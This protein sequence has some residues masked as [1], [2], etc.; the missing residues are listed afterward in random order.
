MGTS[1][2]TSR[3]TRIE[4]GSTYPL[5]FSQAFIWH[6]R[7]WAPAAPAQFWHLPLQIRIR[8][9]LDLDVFLRALGRLVARHESLRT[10]F[11]VL[12]SGEPVQRIAAPGP[13]VAAVVDLRDQTAELQAREVARL[14]QEAFRAPFDLDAAAPF[15]PMVIQLADGEHLFFAVAH[16][17][18]ADAWSQGLFLREL[19]AD[20]RGDGS[21]VPEPALQ[22][23][24]YAVW[25]RRQ[26]E[27]GGFAAMIDYWVGQLSPPFAGLGLPTRGSPFAGGIERFAIPPELVDQAGALG[28]SLGGTP[29]SAF[30]A[31][32]YL[33]LHLH[34]GRS[35]LLVSVPV[36]SRPRNCLD[37]LG[38]FAKQ[39][40]YRLR[41][42]DDPSF[43]ELVRRVQEVNRGAQANQAAPVMKAVER[44]GLRHAPQAALGKAVFIFQ[45]ALVPRAEAKGVSFDL[46]NRWDLLD[47]A[48][49]D[50]V[51]Q[52][53]ATPTG[54]EGWIEYRTALYTDSFVRRLATD[55]L[56]L[57]AR[58]FEDPTRTLST[59]GKAP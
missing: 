32:F 8:G 53:M 20:Y 7:L 30:L 18:V 46:E 31:G 57:L 27:N 17:L 43:A 10:T 51:W 58:V 44:L 28:S 49:E 54:L 13:T 4:R 56:Q 23:V 16:H 29:F 39:V 42:T 6:H 50:I 34:T 41:F 24:D 12:P 14:T 48:R 40:P 1:P 5:S 11:H 35:D 19:V 33:L 21:G 47:F 37:V 26:T 25:Q 45:N 38:C 9:K 52:V 36:A 55:Y 15:R 22:Y 2:A 3:P 59:F